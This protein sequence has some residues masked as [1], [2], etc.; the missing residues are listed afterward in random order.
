[1]S[2]VSAVVPVLWEPVKESSLQKVSLIVFYSF[3]K[4]SPKPESCPQIHRRKLAKPRVVLAIMLML[5]CNV[6]CQMEDLCYSPIMAGDIPS[7]LLCAVSASHGNIIESL[8]PAMQVHPSYTL[9]SILSKFP[10]VKIMVTVPSL[11]ISWKKSRSLIFSHTSQSS[12]VV[13]TYCFPFSLRWSIFH[14][15]ILKGT[16]SPPHM[17][18]KWAKYGMSL[19]ISPRYISSGFSFI[20]L[21]PQWSVIP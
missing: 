3:T 21:P 2:D 8:F 18:N 13:K 19:T 10:A 5:T 14:C 6:D 11:G 17:E 12:L 16:H 7:H 4:I 1:M 15:C 9:H 20:S